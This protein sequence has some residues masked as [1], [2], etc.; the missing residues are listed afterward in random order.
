MI[1]TQRGGSDEKEKIV[2]NLCIHSLI[3][4]KESFHSDKHNLQKNDTKKSV[5]NV[6]QISYYS[7]TICNFGQKALHPG[8]EF[9]LRASKIEKL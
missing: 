9:R 1:P 4:V 5:T 8:S 7:V 3:Y 6:S 2:H